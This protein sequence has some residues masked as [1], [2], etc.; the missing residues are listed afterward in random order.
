VSESVL[1]LL[2]Q[3]S[4]ELRSQ[5]C[6]MTSFLKISKTK[7]EDGCQLNKAPSSPHHGS[8][9]FSLLTLS[10]SFDSF[11]P[12]LGVLFGD[13]ITIIVVMEEESPPLSSYRDRAMLLLP[14]DHYSGH[15]LAFL[16]VRD[17][18]SFATTSRQA[19]AT[20]LPT[21]RSIQNSLFFD[22]ALL[23]SE[24]AS[25]TTT[26]R[27]LQQHPPAASRAEPVHS[28]FKMTLHERI[29]ILAELIPSKYSNR[30]KIQ[31]LRAALQ[32]LLTASSSAAVR[33]RQRPRQVL[34]TTCCVNAAATSSAFC[35]DDDDDDDEYQN[36]ANNNNCTTTRR[37]GELQS[38]MLPFR[39]LHQLTWSF[40]PVVR[41][42]HREDD[43]DDGDDPIMTTTAKRTCSSSSS[44]GSCLLDDYL[45]D[46]YVV[47]YLLLSQQQQ[48]RLHRIIGDGTLPL[49]GQKRSNIDNN[50][51]RADNGGDTTSTT[52]TFAARYG[53]WVYWHAQWLTRP[54]LLTTE[55]KVRFGVWAASAV[56]MDRHDDDEAEMAVVIAP[57]PAVQRAMAPSS[58]SVLTLV[59]DDFAPLM[60]GLPHFR[61]RDIV[62]MLD[63]SAAVMM[64]NDYNTTNDA[65][66]SSSS[67]S[68]L[69]LAVVREWIVSAHEQALSHRPMTV[70]PPEVRFG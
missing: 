4:N 9:T 57:S 68:T 20:S 54:G 64:M 56:A 51:F 19:L 38:L 53:D 63:V 41:R 39:L 2:F 13:T 17:I 7:N 15:I 34:G 16:S 21:L 22:R 1:S 31:A 23:L 35:H 40:S 49:P 26:A 61:G 10:F 65:D 55:Q 8:S 14:A 60:L 47:L 5:N 12:V 33:R 11:D 45:G 30:A 3:T 62:R 67:S 50:Q 42:R 29:Q 25:A 27:P 6:P 24:S 59:Y 37:I 69:L 70:R 48:N 58:S 66:S 18:V 52:I 32:Q 28:S 44:S 43:S 46:V 36:D